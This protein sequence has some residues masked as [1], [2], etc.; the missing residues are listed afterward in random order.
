MNKLRVPENLRDEIEEEL[1]EQGFLDESR[2]AEAFCKGKLRNNRWGK[3]KLI[4]QLKALKIPEDIIENSISE[5]DN[6]EY[7]ET[8]RALIARNRNKY[9]DP[10]HSTNKLKLMKFLYQKGFDTYDIQQVMDE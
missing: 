3:R 5:I 1:K 4:F 2:F 8:I 9:G 10:S 7:K 6:D